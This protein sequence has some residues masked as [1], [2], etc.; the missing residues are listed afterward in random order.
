MLTQTNDTRITLG[1]TMLEDKI[2]DI[3][4]EIDKLH[5]ND[6]MIGEKLIHPPPEKNRR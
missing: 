2:A 5:H 6:D 3:K 1:Q 4:I